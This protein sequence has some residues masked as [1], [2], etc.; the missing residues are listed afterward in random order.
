MVTSIE[1]GDMQFTA[2][3]GCSKLA[4]QVASIDYGPWRYFVSYGYKTVTGVMFSGGIWGHTYFVVRDE[5]L[6]F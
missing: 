3:K 4:V 1:V 2:Q 6:G 5:I